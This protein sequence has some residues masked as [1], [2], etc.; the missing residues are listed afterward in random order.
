MT[1]RTRL[2]RTSPAS[3]RKI[4]STLDEIVTSDCEEP[5]PSD[6]P[7]LERIDPEF[8]YDDTPSSASDLSISLIE[9]PPCPDF[10]SLEYLMHQLRMFILNKVI[11]NI[12]IFLY[13]KYEIHSIYGVCNSS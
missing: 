3:E 13:S 8:T 9:P 7:I 1:C 10:F 4:E 2:P 5:V 12:T 11:N 6:V